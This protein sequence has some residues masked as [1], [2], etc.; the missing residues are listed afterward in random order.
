MYVYLF[1]ELVTIK[2]NRV[3]EQTRQNVNKFKDEKITEQT[4]ILQ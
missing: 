2:Q 4:F 3:K 1:Y